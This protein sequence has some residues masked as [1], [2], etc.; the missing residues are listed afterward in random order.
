MDSL[1]FSIFLMVV[2]CVLF[3]SN[4]FGNLAVICGL[5]AMC[6][7]FVIFL[8]WRPGVTLLVM[9]VFVLLCLVIMSFVGLIKA[10]GSLKWFEPED[11]H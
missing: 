4:K 10:I 9:G 8:C 6:V 3:R 7:G 2:G 11:G 1:Y 5:F